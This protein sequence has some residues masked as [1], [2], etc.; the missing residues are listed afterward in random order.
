MFAHHNKYVNKMSAKIST[1]PRVA[2]AT[3]DAKFGNMALWGGVAFSALFT[4]FIWLTGDRLVAFAKP[5]DQGPFWY[6]WILESPTW[7]TR[8][9][10]WGSYAAHQLAI[11]GLIYYA[12]TQVKTYTQGLHRVNMWALAVN[13]GF[14]VWH[15]LHT[16]LFYDK[17]AQDTS[18]FSSQGSVILMLVWIILMEN[19]RRGMFF[20]KPLPFGKS[21]IDFAKKY[22]GYVFS[23]ATVYTFWYH[24]AEHTQGHLIGFFYMFLLL[25]QGSLFLTRIHVN[26]WW[27]L[28]Q[29]LTVLVH[30]GLVA[31]QQVQ[32]DL[33]QVI[34][35]MFAFGFGVIFIVTQ[36]HGLGLKR[37]QKWL[38]YALFALAL[39]F[40]YG[41][42]G[43]HQI[44]EIIRVPAIEYICAIV[45]GLLIALGIGIK[46]G[47]ESLRQRFQLARSAS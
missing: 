21:V 12:Q 13:A 19:K 20:G 32:G 45:L 25:L 40:I 15:W 41:Q 7:A 46:R 37:W 8:A 30:G 3:N 29:E 11:W 10:A 39:A 28:T 34:W 16:H 24:P 2:T 47:I 33:T 43:W 36:M 6:Y 9:L 1:Q 38:I 27:M 42:R 26:R 17:L 5:E 44:N 14:I 4:L 35:P 23:W 18:I 31:A 22:H